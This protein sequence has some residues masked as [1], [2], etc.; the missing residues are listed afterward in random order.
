MPDYKNKSKT[1]IMNNNN[2]IQINETTD[3][4]RFKFLH[5]NRNVNKNHVQRLKNSMTKNYLHTVITVNQNY[6]VID[7]QHRLTACSELGLPVKYVM[8]KN[9]GLKEVQ[10]LNAMTSNWT[11]GQYLDSYCTKGYQDYIDYKRFKL[12]YNLSHRENILLLCS[13]DIRTHEEKFK[14]G[15]FK[16]I[17][18]KKACY[19]GDELSKVAEFYKGYNRR[20]F[21]RAIY[22]LLNKPEFSMD[23]FLQKLTFQ[24]TAL[25]DCVNRDSYLS[26]IEEIY[27]YKRRMKIN[28]KY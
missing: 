27:N 2:N 17:N 13:P 11:T 8:L 25:V 1:K 19:Y 9:Y 24:R 26:L 20:Y 23:E 12:K 22:F 6:E 4:S 14:D 16:V 5:G 3:Y 18:Y 21:V 28:L 7:G 15:S 10:T